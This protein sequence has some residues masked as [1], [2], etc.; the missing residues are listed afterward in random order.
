MTENANL[1]KTA[2]AQP[3]LVVFGG[4]SELTTAG[5]SGPLEGAMGSALMRVRP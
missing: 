4:F 3:K 5:S 2:Y 1:A